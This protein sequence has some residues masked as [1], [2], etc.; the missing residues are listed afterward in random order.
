MGNYFTQRENYKSSTIINYLCYYLTINNTR[1]QVYFINTRSI[2]RY[3]IR[4]SEN[5]LVI[6]D[7]F[8]GIQYNLDITHLTKNDCALTGKY[9]DDNITRKRIFSFKFIDDFATNK[10]TFGWRTKVSVMERNYLIEYLGLF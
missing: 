8:K 7:L 3:E 6:V 10:N 5:K 1:K 2:E 4:R 9:L